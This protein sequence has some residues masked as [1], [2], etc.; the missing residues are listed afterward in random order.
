MAVTEITKIL[1]RRGTAQ[2]RASLE[3][4][5]GLA[6]GEPGFTIQGSWVGD[7]PTRYD[8]RSSF[9]SNTD[10]VQYNTETGGGDL[11][12]G[13]NE[14]KDIYIGG[15]SAEKHWQ[16]YFVSLRGTGYNTNWSDDTGVNTLSGFVDGRFV[17]GK[18]GGT[19]NRTPASD[20]WDVIFYGP[21]TSTDVALYDNNTRAFMWKP[22]QEAVEL[23]SNTSLKLPVGTTDQ[24]PGGAEFS[25]YPATTG[26]IRYNTT[27]AVFE[28]HDGSGWIN[29][30]G[31]NS[32]DKKTYIT[33]EPRT[34]PDGCGNLLGQTNELTFVT[35]CT[36]G[37]RLDQYGNLHVRGDV[38]SRDIN[39]PEGVVRSYLRFR[40]SGGAEQI[41]TPGGGYIDA[42]DSDNNIIE[43]IQAGVYDITTNAT[44]KEP[45]AVVASGTGK[46]GFTLQSQQPAVISVQ[47][48]S[49][50]GVTNFD[51]VTGS[52]IKIRVVQP[53]VK[54][55]REAKDGDTGWSFEYRDDSNEPTIQVP[56]MPTLSATG[57][58][59]LEQALDF[60]SGTYERDDVTHN[61]KNVYVK[62]GDV[63]N[64]YIYANQYTGS[65]TDQ[66]WILGTSDP[67]VTPLDTSFGNGWIAFGQAVAALP[68]DS[69]FDN[70]V[71]SNKI[72]YTLNTV[73][74]DI[75]IGGG[76]DDWS[77]SVI[78]AGR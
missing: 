54:K 40:S 10:V 50:G 53:Y 37:A 42:T 45:P 68:A 23:W 4:Y 30:G 47:S 15:S 18:A 59:T 21:E 69:V 19:T 51:P 17:V 48:T 75:T 76:A 6:Q 1:F 29:F 16:H 2:D 78:V 24:R 73:G 8:N 77:I 5:G 28:G 72:Q 34:Q 9:L 26:M 49:P 25:D 56:S 60:I 27:N 58:V 70:V 7:A 39:L 52:Q 64:W 61:G 3:S 43:R 74:Q 71:S 31:V 11:F 55:G 12:M 20:P 57:D 62:R 46:T 63:A 35:N 65:S 14:G 22:V 32:T 41:Y 66:H 36:S 33:P 67:Q 44:Y 38:I 13:G